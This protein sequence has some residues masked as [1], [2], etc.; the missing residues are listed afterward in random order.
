MRVAAITHREA[1]D[2]LLC[3]FQR[4]PK[5]GMEIVCFPA[6]KKVDRSDYHGAKV[7]PLREME[8]VDA[9]LIAFTTPERVKTALDLLH[10]VPDAGRIKYYLLTPDAILS[11]ADFLSDDMTDDKAF[12]EL[13]YRNGKLFLDIDPSEFV[14]NSSESMRAKIQQLWA[15]NES[16]RTENDRLL[17]QMDAYF[18]GSI[19]SSPASALPDSF[20]NTSR[21]PVERVRVVVV[22]DVRVTAYGLHN[23]VDPGCSAMPIAAIASGY[24][25][26][27]CAL[28]GVT[29]TDIYGKLLH[30]TASA[31]PIDTSRF[32]AM[33]H[34][35]TGRLKIFL[36]KNGDRFFESENYAPG[37][38]DAHMFC[39]GDVCKIAMADYVMVS[40]DS[41]ELRQLL[42]LKKE[43]PFK[44]CVDW[45]TYNDLKYIENVIPQTDCSFFSAERRDVDEML[46]QMNQ[47]SKEYPA[48][49][50]MTM[51]EHGSVA[52]RNGIEYRAE[53][54]PA[55]QVVDTAGCG[56]SYRA[57]FLFSYVRDGDIEAAM[58]EGHRL[59]AKCASHFG[60]F[61][62][63]SH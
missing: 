43:A 38:N 4:H 55:D 1:R 54:V 30:D 48:L 44:M 13:H 40:G 61:E 3:T 52:Y 45:H 24:D 22:S 32:C 17:E 53:A 19:T 28:V 14:N 42:D 50:I 11:Q 16:L 41:W 29:G 15:E 20:R 18:D 8:G 6:L 7:I 36:D 23:K 12:R 58:R 33:R 56:D 62:F 9:V 47:W 27:D 34:K 46:K 25:H 49:L 57:G 51:A 63:E 10:D 37:C 35:L 26:I 39:E 2:Y 59:A 60:L 5:C 21:T 31:L